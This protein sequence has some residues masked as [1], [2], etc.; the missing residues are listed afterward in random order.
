MPLRQDNKKALQNAGLF[1]RL[2]STTKENRNYR[3][4]KISH[5]VTSLDFLLTRALYIDW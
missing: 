5:Q 4:Y 2:K 3:R 1:F